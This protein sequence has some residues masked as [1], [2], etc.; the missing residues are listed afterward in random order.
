MSSGACECRGPGL[1]VKC[2]GPP[3]YKCSDLLHCICRAG[4]DAYGQAAAPAA[5]PDQ[6]LEWRRSIYSRNVWALPV[7]VG[8]SGGAG[9]DGGGGSSGNGVVVVP[10]PNASAPAGQ[11]RLQDWVARELQALLQQE[12]SC[13]ACAW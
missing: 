2:G 7:R 8:S 13:A 3:C 12:V 5:A 10:P 9:G 1:D 4:V 6:A 11:Q